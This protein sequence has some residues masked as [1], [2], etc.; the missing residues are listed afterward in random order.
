MILNPGKV[1]ALVGATANNL[2]STLREQKISGLFI[3]DEFIPRDPAAYQQEQGWVVVAHPY[4]EGCD[5]FFVGED[6]IFSQTDPQGY[7]RVLVQDRDTEAMMERAD[8]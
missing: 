2:S 8:A 3:C 1:V 7:A 4:V 5:A 6:E